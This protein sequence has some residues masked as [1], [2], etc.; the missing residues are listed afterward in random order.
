MQA[1][2]EFLAHLEQKVGKPAVEKWLRPLK[3]ARFDAC[4][5]YLEAENTFQVAWFEEHIRKYA[6]EHFH[7]KNAHPIKVHFLTQ[8]HSK[9]RKN[10]A[11]Q[12]H[13]S[14]SPLELSSIPID[15]TQTFSNFLYEEKNAVTVE[16]CKRLVPGTFNPLFLFGP[17][18]S[19]KSHLLMACANRLKKA[20]LRTF[21]VNAETFTEH[22]VK[23]IRNSQMQNF[24]DIYRNQD[25]LILDDTHFLAHRLATQEEFFHTFNTLHMEGKQLILS[26][27]QP[28]HQMEGI[29]PRL[30]SRFEWGI[31]LEVSPLSKK[32]FAQVLK[33]R[34]HLHRFALSDAMVTFLLKH[35][36]SSTHSMMRALEALFLRHRSPSAI[37]LEEATFLLSDLLQEEEK[38]KLTYQKILS[39][40]ASYYGIRVE[41][42]LS[43]SQ[44]REYVTPRKLAMY[45]CRKQL[46]LSYISIGK[47]FKRDHSTVITS[48]RD[49][50]KNS[51]ADEL[52]IALSEIETS[53]KIK[54]L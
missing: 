40:T 5:L 21:F 26:G 45:L 39:K 10:T 24:R 30:T 28:P 4:N 29:E 11:K 2:D 42:I 41:D 35:F 53:L 14:L 8:L 43:K 12:T 9:K 22:V 31:V 19:G 17:P 23:A 51:S 20:G 3:V 34:A 32:K 15:P 18:G 38:L 50:E 33:N 36:Y 27:N 1:W 44:S 6:K 49:V 37:S 16:L 52:H 48:I 54:S 47:I 7:N 25:V 13:F 46:D